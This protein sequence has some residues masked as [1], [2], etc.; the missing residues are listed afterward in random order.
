MRTIK[1]NPQLHIVNLQQLAAGI[2]AKYLLCIDDDIHKS[3]IA[4]EWRRTNKKPLVDIDKQ[5]L[6]EF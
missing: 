2:G 3:L 4:V 5:V 1:Y 6:V